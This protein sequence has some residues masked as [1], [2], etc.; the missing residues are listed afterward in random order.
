[1]ILKALYDYY[2]RSGKYVAPIGWA[3]VPFFYSIVLDCAG[4]FIRLEPLGDKDGLPL[5]TF[6]PEERT[7]AP[8]PHCMGD[9][10]S[11]L[12]GLKDIK[13]KEDF[14]F[15]KEL[16]NNNKNFDAFKKEIDSV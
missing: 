6:R 4:N 3:Y 1:M 9:N 11:Y 2:N 5:L 10:G 12:L 16:K 14:D 15:A 7:S 8:L 13:D